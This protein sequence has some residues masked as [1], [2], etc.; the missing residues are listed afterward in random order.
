MYCDQIEQQPLG[1]SLARCLRVLRYPASDGHHAFDVY[2]APV[3]KTQF[4]KIAFEVLFKMGKRVPSPTRRTRPCSS[5][6]SAA[7]TYE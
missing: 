5:F 1:N 4:Q 7:G 3:E 6:A 2:Y